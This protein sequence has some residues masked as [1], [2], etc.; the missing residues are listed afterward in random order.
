MRVDEARAKT[1]EGMLLAVQPQAIVLKM[2]AGNV[3]VPFAQIR[4]AKKTLRW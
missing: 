2:E 1:L 4:A 3:T